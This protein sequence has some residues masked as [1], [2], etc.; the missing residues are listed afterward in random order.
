[1]DK[2]I[3]KIIGLG[4]GGAKVVNKMH[5]AGVGKGR[6]VKFICV[7]TDENIM[8]TSN[9][10]QNL[11]MNRDL[12]TLYKNFSDALQG[13]KLIFIVGG[14]GSN[15]ARGALPI[16]T[17]CAKNLDAVTVAFVCRPFVLENVVRKAN[18][19][20]NWDNLRG[21]VD[22]L[23]MVPA[24]K[25]FLFRMNQ[26]QV[27]LNEVFDAADDIFC[28]GVE[29]FL[30]MLLEGDENLTLLRWGNAAF[31]YAEA[32]TATDAIK[33]AAKFP[34]LDENDIKNA[35]GIFVRIIGGKTLPLA[36]VEAANDFIRQQLQPEAEFFS[37]E[38]T[39]AALGDKVFASI[40]LTRKEVVK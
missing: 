19:R 11:F 30:D 20:Y 17:S 31:S 38:D 6:A 28:R 25:F 24:E 36:S 5:A 26:P 22:T 23:I 27:S 37:Q 12:A 4:E 18:A 16:I 32:T 21:K 15:A 29:I 40:I 13:A 39:N 10:R 34:T 35:E 9:I 8:L 1:M 2:L 33:A 14:L 7:G 3:I